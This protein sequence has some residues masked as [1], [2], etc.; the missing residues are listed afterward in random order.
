MQDRWTFSSD[1]NSNFDGQ[2]WGAA[3]NGLFVGI[4]VAALALGVVAL[5]VR[6]ITTRNRVG[7]RDA[8]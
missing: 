8:R 1:F 5:L 4:L 7:L 3:P 6:R 2:Q